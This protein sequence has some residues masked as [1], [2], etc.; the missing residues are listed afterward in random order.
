MN[1]QKNTK[2]K[3]CISS[4][5]SPNPSECE[6]EKVGKERERILQGDDE[7]HSTVILV[8]QYLHQKNPFGQKQSRKVSSAKG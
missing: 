7:M 5:P 8:E 6:K 2:P 4:H 1:W 3:C